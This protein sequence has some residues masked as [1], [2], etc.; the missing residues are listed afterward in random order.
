MLG[1]SLSIIA[2]GFILISAMAVIGL[3]YLIVFALLPKRVQQKIWDWVEGDLV[4]LDNSD[5][6][7]K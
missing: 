6:Q 1:S 5:E 3:V 7:E 2:N 4:E